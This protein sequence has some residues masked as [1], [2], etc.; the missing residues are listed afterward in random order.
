MRAHVYVLFETRNFEDHSELDLAMVGGTYQ[1]LID[2]YIA[3]KGHAPRTIDEN[4]VNGHPV[5]LL[6]H[7]EVGQAVIARYAV[8]I[9]EIID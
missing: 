4:L 3:W 7:N 5:W 8:G 1:E 9:Q 6:D 2:Y